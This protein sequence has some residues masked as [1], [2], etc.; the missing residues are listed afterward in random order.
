MRV[1][2]VRDWTCW[3]FNSARSQFVYSYISNF[4]SSRQRRIG[5]VATTSRSTKNRWNP[6]Y[7]WHFVEL[8]KNGFKTLS[9]LRWLSTSWGERLVQHHLQCK[10]YAS[11]ALLEAKCYALLFYAFLNHYQISSEKE[12]NRITNAPKYFFTKNFCA[13]LKEMGKCFL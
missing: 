8:L 11:N 3:T 5:G 13:A 6:H 10:A 7:I 9:T 12:N 2:G 1:S 4:P